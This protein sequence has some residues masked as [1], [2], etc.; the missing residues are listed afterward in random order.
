VKK[1][2]TG[3]VTAGVLKAP[4]AWA[5]SINGRI[6]RVKRQACGFRNPT[7]FQRAIDGHLARLDLHPACINHKKS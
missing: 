6:Q 2:L 7:R 4:H 1:H 5:G 3:L